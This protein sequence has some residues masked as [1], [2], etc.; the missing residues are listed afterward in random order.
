MATQGA[1]SVRFLQCCLK[2]AWLGLLREKRRMT[3]RLSALRDDER[4]LIYDSTAIAA[5]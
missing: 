5:V 1:G 4:R 2:K 3:L